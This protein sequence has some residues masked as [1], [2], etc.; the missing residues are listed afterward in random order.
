MKI[1]REGAWKYAL[2]MA[3][4][5]SA[6]WLEQI[7][8]RDLKVEAKTKIITQPG[9]WIQLLFRIIRI[10]ERGSIA[11]KIEKLKQ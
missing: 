11:D 2:K 6:N 10:R 8:A 3:E 4:A 9:K 5:N 7:N 1:A